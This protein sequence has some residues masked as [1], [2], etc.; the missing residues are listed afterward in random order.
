MHQHWFSP[1]PNGSWGPAPGE[2]CDWVEDAVETPQ[3][4]RPLEFLAG[5]LLPDATGVGR[6]SNRQM[7]LLIDEF[8][9]LLTLRRSSFFG[10]IC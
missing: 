2:P 6:N 10:A 7:S 3:L 8:L 4:V 5:L 9:N 1:Y